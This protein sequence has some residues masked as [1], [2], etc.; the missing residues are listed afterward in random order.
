VGRARVRAAP[1]R[2]EG[3]GPAPEQQRGGGL[4]DRGDHLEGAGEGFP[5][6]DLVGAH[7]IHGPAEVA[8]GS[9]L[10]EPP[11]SAIPVRRTHERH[12]RCG[13][14]QL[15]SG[16]G[17]D[18]ESAGAQRP[19]RLSGFCEEQAAHVSKAGRFSQRIFREQRP[20]GPAKLPV[21]L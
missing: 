17:A 8:V 7:G 5:A 19:L 2:A 10:A 4:R 16:S 14:G 6:D 3:A 18:P 15:P 11:R 21:R 12:F 13:I 9:R 1:D 20:R